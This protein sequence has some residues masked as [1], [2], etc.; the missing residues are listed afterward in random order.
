MSQLCRDTNEVI[1]VAHDD[2]VDPSSR[3]IVIS[4]YWKRFVQVPEKNEILYVQN[5][6]PEGTN[7][8]EFVSLEVVLFWAFDEANNKDVLVAWN[9]RISTS[10]VLRWTIVSTEN[11]SII[12]LDEHAVRMFNNVEAAETA[13]PNKEL[14]VLTDENIN[15]WKSFHVHSPLEG[16]DRR[17]D[18]I[19]RC[20][21]VETFSMPGHTV[22]PVVWWASDPSLSP[23]IDVVCPSVK[24]ELPSPTEQT[25]GCYPTVLMI[26]ARKKSLIITVVTW[27]RTGNSTRI[28]L[29]WKKFTGERAKAVMTRS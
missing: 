19:M 26:G 11:W 6:T 23:G 27:S 20:S 21:F 16:L 9:E 3:C 22:I 17:C 24:N 15:G 8:R 29:F 12:P 18:A 1:F 10:T 5:C 14:I 13:C 25:N 4:G 2:F 28:S 7:N